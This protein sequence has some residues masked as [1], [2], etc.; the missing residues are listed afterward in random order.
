M[1]KRDCRWAKTHIKPAK[2]RLLAD[3][4]LKFGENGGMCVGR[5]LVDDE[6]LVGALLNKVAR[7][8]RRANL[9][10][11][12]LQE[13]AGAL[14]FTREARRRYLHNLLAR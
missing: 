14:G 12:R 9:R 13:A 5:R 10:V 2:F 1:R 8:V 4:E 7:V 6:R 11:E 3:R